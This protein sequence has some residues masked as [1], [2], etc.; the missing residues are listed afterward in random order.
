[1]GLILTCS[2]VLSPDRVKLVGRTEGS[3]PNL[4]TVQCGVPGNEKRRGSSAPGEC[5]WGPG[6]QKNLVTMG[7]EED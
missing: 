4:E 1:M 7:D 6:S 2:C 3:G 5:P